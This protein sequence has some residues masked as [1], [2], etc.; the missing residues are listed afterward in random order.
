M[1]SRMSNPTVEAFEK[2]MAVL[3]GGVG[4]LATSAGQTASAFSVMNIAQSGQHVV[5]ASKFYGGTFNLFEY[6]L[7]KCGIDPSYHGFSY[8]ET[9]GKMAFFLKKSK[10][11]QKSHFPG[12]KSISTFANISNPYENCNIIRCSW[13]R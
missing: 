8:T 5:A 1:Y 3:E 7:R 13:F 11:S 6:S 10:K 9:F 12:L 4:A 2:K